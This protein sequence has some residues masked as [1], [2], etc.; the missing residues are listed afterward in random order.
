[1]AELNRLSDKL[2][3]SRLVREKAAIIY[4]K[5]LEK[6]IIK[7]RTIVA[8][9][10]AS[11][12]AACRITRTPR[13]L[14]EISKFCYIEKKEIG[15]C[16]RLILKKL[17]FQM[18]LADPFMYLSKIAEKIDIS[19]STQSYAAKI[20]HITKRKYLLIDKDPKGS[21]AA[22]LYIACRYKNEKVRQQ[23]IVIAAE[24]SE[25]TIRNRYKSI[26]KNLNL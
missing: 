20:L 6:D 13:T 12:Y 2:N 4:R 1:M 18:P 11:L 26:K 10:A 19:G 3:I 15:S 17:E 24:I 7:G 9:T 14:Q 8:V 21:A 23:E 5:P 16:Y 22:V 25:V